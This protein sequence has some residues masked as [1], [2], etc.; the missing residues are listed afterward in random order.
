MEMCILKNSSICAS[1]QTNMKPSM[2]VYFVRY[3]FLCLV[4]CSRDFLVPGCLLVGSLA[5][6]KYIRQIGE[7]K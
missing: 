6:S 5:G 1:A 7:E 4:L 2:S 3:I